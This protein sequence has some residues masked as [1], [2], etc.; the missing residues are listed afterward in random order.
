MYNAYMAV[1]S[2]SG[3]RKALSR[4]TQ[5]LSFMEEIGFEEGGD[6]TVRVGTVSALGRFFNS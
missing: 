6:D 2:K 4:V 3:D 1:W 5:L